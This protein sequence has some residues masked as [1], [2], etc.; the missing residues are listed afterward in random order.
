[1]KKTFF[2]VLLSLFVFSVFSIVLPAAEPVKIIFDTD[3]GNDVD[4]VMAM[5]VIHALQNRHECELLAVTITKDNKYAAPMAE[6][7]NRFYGRSDIPVGMVK[8]GVTKEDGRY[9]VPVVEA[10]N[11]DGFPV[12]PTVIT[13]ENSKNCTDAVVLLR[14]VLA[15]QAD[16]SVVIVQVGFSTNL[17]GLLDTPG[18]ELSPLTGKELLKHK[19]TYCSLMAGA[20]IPQ[21]AKH[22][23]YNIAC[24]IPAARKFF[25][26][27]PCPVVLSGYEI[28]EMIQSA[29][30]SQQNGYCYVKNH[31]VQLAYKYYR[32]LENDQPLFDLTSVLYAVRPGWNYF[33]L[34]EPG[35]VTVN[36]DATVVFTPSENGRFRYLTVTP[37]QVAAVREAL[38]HLASEPPQKQNGWVR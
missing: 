1:M 5:G 16:R 22:K 18:D 13:P 17:A 9:L 19:V 35:N 3:I 20:F 37:E 12:F 6:L 10:K 7:L 21:L 31:P 34:S 11:A 15:E 38:C 8:N 2:W 33:G 29:A 14:K 23:E 32:G 30:V 25:A 4:D 26:E 36:D 28:G 24:D 27:C